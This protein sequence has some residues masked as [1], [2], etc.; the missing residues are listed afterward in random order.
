MVRRAKWTVKVI[1][2]LCVVSL[3]VVMYPAPSIAT[4]EKELSEVGCKI[5]LHLNGTS[6]KGG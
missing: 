2:D 1:V 4:C 3:G 6:I 5:Q